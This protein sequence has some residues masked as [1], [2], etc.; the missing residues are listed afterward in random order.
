TI[1]CKH[2]GHTLHTELNPRQWHALLADYPL[3]QWAYRLVHDIIYGVDIGYT[4]V[5]KQTR[6][7]RNWVE[8]G[9][10]TQAV[11]GEIDKDVQ[12][13]RMIGPYS[14][15]PFKHW[16]IS[17][18]MTVPK[19]G[20]IGKWRVV[21]HLSHPWGRSINSFTK[22]WPCTLTRFAVAIKTVCKL[23]KDCMMSKLDIKSAYRLIPIRPNDWPLLGLKWKQSFYFHTSLPFGLKSSCNIWERYATAAQW[24]VR[25]KLNIQDLDHYVDDY[26]LA[27]AS[28]PVCKRQLDGIIEIFQQLGMIIA[29]DKTVEPTTRLVYLGITIDSNEMAISLGPDK[30]TAIMEL[31]D[32]WTD[33]DTCSMKQLQSVIGTL[34]WAANVVTHGRTFIQRLRDLEHKYIHLDNHTDESAI[35]IND[36]S[37]EDVEWWRTFIRQWNGVSLL[38]DQEWLD[39]KHILQPFTDACD[40]G[41][42]AVCGKDWFHGQWNQEQEDMAND[43]TSQRASMPWKELFALVT[44]A[45]TW[46][47][48]WNRRRITFRTDCQPVVDVLTKGATRSKRMMQLVRFLHYHAAKHSFVYRVIHIAGKDNIIA[49]ELSR[50]HVLS[51]FSQECRNNINPL[52]TIPVLPLIQK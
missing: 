48:Q 12:L 26:F 50:V 52:P 43:G 5:R 45:A 7:A 27:A 40:A 34:Q 8:D 29:T 31:L 41:Y 3:R 23:G 9:V 24:I 32:E 2:S 28:Y 51:Q 42:G 11:D 49:D 30:I 21:H 25:N 36:E 6:Q 35:I 46:G 4:G 1:T 13:Q 18:L 39:D 17:P 16:I 15:P 47:H 37:R 33:C 44:A 38:W 19:K 20:S 10:Q 14:V 22:D